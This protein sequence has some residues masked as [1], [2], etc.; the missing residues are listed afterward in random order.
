MV[1]CCRSSGR[2]NFSLTL[3][4]FL[5][6]FSLSVE[7]ILPLLFS[8]AFSCTHWILQKKTFS[9]AMKSVGPVLRSKVIPPRDQRLLTLS[10]VVFIYLQLFFFRSYHKFTHVDNL[11]DI[12]M[13]IQTSAFL[14]FLTVFSFCTSCRFLGVL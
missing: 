11:A 6:R 5:N 14:V 3:I 4:L 12:T 9:G 2:W 13:K 1:T 10:S 8:V 7:N